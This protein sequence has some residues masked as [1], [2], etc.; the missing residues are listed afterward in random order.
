MPRDEEQ[1]RCHDFAAL[2]ALGE[3]RGYADAELWA[4]KVMEG[5][6]RRLARRTS[7]RSRRGRWWLD[8]PRK[9]S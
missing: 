2:V 1:G 5:R 7:L 9:E 4:R 3:R 6:E 8:Q